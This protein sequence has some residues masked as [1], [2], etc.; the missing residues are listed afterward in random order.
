[1]FPIGS[2]LDL[3]LALNESILCAACSA[4]YRVLDLSERSLGRVQVLP[5]DDN[6][7][8]V[9][10]SCCPKC[11]PGRLATFLRPTPTRKEL[12][13][14]LETALTHWQSARPDDADWIRSI[15]KE[16]LLP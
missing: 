7:T 11:A 9:E 12:R 2:N 13:A 14:A 16:L 15:R 3:P 1:M 4:T 6:D 10:A 8:H 5:S